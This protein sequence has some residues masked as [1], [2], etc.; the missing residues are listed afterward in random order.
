[1]SIKVRITKKRTVS[2]SGV[3]YSD[4]RSILTMAV[5]RGRD[6]LDQVTKELKNN[7]LTPGEAEQEKVFYNHLLQVICDI[8]EVAGVEHKRVVIDGGGWK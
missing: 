3:G 1:M 5:L 2:V 7:T 8:E 4:L 6:R